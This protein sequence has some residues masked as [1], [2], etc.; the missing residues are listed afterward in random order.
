MARGE[1]DGRRFHD[2]IVA[3]ALED[4]NDPNNPYQTPWDHMLKMVPD[5]DQLDQLRS[6]HDPEYVTIVFRGVAEMEGNRD[7]DKPDDWRTGSALKTMGTRARAPSLTSI[8]RPKMRPYGRPWIEWRSIG[9]SSL[10]R[11]A[12]IYNGRI[13][14]VKNR[15]QMCR[16]IPTLQESSKLP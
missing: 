10:R 2:Q 14:T 13:R 5:I 16:L 7:L 9:P 6:Q 1:V 3:A 15:G 11:I 12:K 4:P 8:R